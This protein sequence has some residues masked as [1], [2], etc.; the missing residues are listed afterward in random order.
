MS[1]FKHPHFPDPVPPA[2][3]PAWS[4]AARAQGANA[5]SEPQAPEDSDV[6]AETEES[7][8]VSVRVSADETRAS[9]GGELVQAPLEPDLGRPWKDVEKELRPY[10]NPRRE[11]LATFPLLTEEQMRH[12]WQGLGFEEDITLLYGN[13]SIVERSREQLRFMSQNDGDGIDIA[14]PDFQKRLAERDFVMFD[15]LG[16]RQATIIATGLEEDLKTVYDETTG[17]ATKV[18]YFRPRT[19][20]EDDKRHKVFFEC[21]KNKRVLMG[22]ATEIVQVENI[23]ITRERELAAQEKIAELRSRIVPSYAT[24]PAALPSATEESVEPE[25]VEGEVQE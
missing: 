7:P 23:D 16:Q 6:Q 15:S 9:L 10:T 14:A 3:P 2:E 22:Q 24:P 13:M 8:K 11:F 21:H 17:F 18:R 25:A 1:R 20:S 19:A 12:R 5:Q 4:R